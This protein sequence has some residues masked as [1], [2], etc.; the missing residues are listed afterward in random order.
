MNFHRRTRTQNQRNGHWHPWAMFSALMLLN[1]AGPAFAQLPTGTILGTVK[2]SSGGVVTGSTVAIKNVETGQSRTVATGD[3]GAYR[4]QALAVGGYEVTVSRDGFQTATRRG[5]TLTVSQEAVVDFTLQVG[6]TGQSVVVTEEAPLVNTTSGSLGGLVNEQKIEDLPLNGRNYVDLSLMQMGVNQQKNVGTTAGMGG[7]WYSANGAPPRSNSY[8]LD[9][10]SMVNLFGATAS[11]VAGTALGVEGIREYKVVTSSVS[12]EYG[13]TMGSQMTLVSKSG[14]NNWHGSAFEFLRNNAIDAANFFD[15][16]P[17]VSGG[18][19]RIAPLRRNQFGGSIGG[20]I[21]QN[22]TFFFTTF[23]GLREL[24]GVPNV[25]TVLPA[26]C[27]NATTHLPLMTGNPCATT[28]TNITG[29]VAAV[30]QPLFSLYPYPNLANVNPSLSANRFGWIFPQGTSENYGQIRAD[31][32]FSANDTFFGRY[33][34]DDTNTSRATGLY[35]QFHNPWQSRSQFVTVSENHVFSPALLNTARFSFSRTNITTDSLSGISNATHPGTSF[36]CSPLYVGAQDA[37]AGGCL[38][39]GTL[40]ITGLTSLA[41]DTSSPSQMKQNIFT[42]SDDVYYTRG[43]HSLKFGTLINRFQQSIY[44]LFQWKGGLTF[45]SNSNFLNGTLFQYNLQDPSHS[46]ENKYWKYSSYGFYVQDDIRLGRHFTLNAGVRYEFNTVP[47]EANGASSFFPQL[48]NPAVTTVSSGTVG[49]FT[50]GPPFQ[51]PSLKNVSPRLGFAWDIFGNGKTSLHGGF[52][53]MF[54]I[55]NVGSALIQGAIGTPP[56]SQQATITTTSVALPL[57]IPASYTPSLRIVNYYLTQPHML[58]YN[59]SVERQLPWQM[60]LTVAYAGSRGLDLLQVQDGNPRT[61]ISGSAT[62][63]A[64]A[65]SSTGAISGTNPRINPNLGSITLLTTAGDSWYN[66]LQVGLTKR[67]THGLQFQS[68][69]TY[70]KT[71]D[72]TQGQLPND[73]GG[74]NTPTNADPF[75]TRYDRGPSGFDLTHN[76]RFNAI[77]QLPDFAH[78]G[79]ASGFVNGWGMSM[80]VSVQTGYPFSP[81]MNTN[82]SGSG[83]SN[84]GGGVDRPNLSALGCSS[85]SAIT[86]T[87]ALWFNPACFTTPDVLAPSS[88]GVGVLGNVAR[89]FLRGPGLESVDFSL[90]KNTGI[91]AL[92]EAGKIQLRVDFFNILN[93]PN[94]AMPAI[95]AA[96]NGTAT[97]VGNAGLIST[98]AGDSRR[99]QLALKILF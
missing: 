21:K 26:S 25:L 64:I 83:V 77:Y 44:Q 35:Q 94:F 55:G 7:V 52:A 70:S 74:I 28:A 59:L 45:T 61:P 30:V 41:P 89:G 79:I 97:G 10:A 33:T 80:I 58:Q 18:A 65:S 39:I 5:L 19:K 2:D 99:V 37:V 27:Y 75:F 42:F 43:R 23:E 71:L 29:T 15:A 50:L 67:V 13:I 32:Y 51:N 57:I 17:T 60:A 86:G 11:S 98:T 9:G 47:S 36:V 22:K 63:W 14:T 48:T 38:E 20:P 1:I 3:D 88:T 78:G 84:G 62:T 49:G 72:D 68:S 85:S 56:F 91:K 8:L 76:W 54:D 93:H 82:P 87:P 24:A 46:N 40:A 6:S 92:G 53:D 12:A 66:G 4:V 81:T 96:Y 90:T 16:T 95:S 31:H 69:Y 34:V 73:T